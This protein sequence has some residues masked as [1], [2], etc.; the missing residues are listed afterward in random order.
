MR[1][2]LIL[3]LFLLFAMPTLFAQIKI[4]DNPQAIAP[5]SVLELESN[6][7]VFVITRITTQ[8]MNA[9]VPSHGAMIYNTDTQCVHYYNGTLWIN[10]CDS[11]GLTLSDDPVVNLFSTI[12]ITDVAGIKHIEVAPN[13]IGGV[14]IIEDGINGEFH[15]ADHSINENQLAPESVTQ[16]KL[17]ENSVGALQLDNAN[18]GLTAFTNDAG[19]ITGT[20]IVSGDTGNNISIGGDNGAFYDN[21]PVLDAIG[22]NTTFINAHIAADL[23]LLPTNELQNLSYNAGSM[24]LTLSDPVNGNDVIDLSALG[25]TGSDNQNLESAILNASNVLQINIENGNSATV[26]LSSL[27]GGGGNPTDELTDIDFNT[28][29]NILTLTNPA[30]V[31]GATVD[32]STLAGGGSQDLGQVLTQGNDA[33]AIQIKNLSNPSLPQDAATKVY[34]DLSDQNLSEVLALDND[35]GASLIKNILDPVDPQDAATRA[36]VLA[37]VASGGSLTDGTILIGGT[38]NV[39]Q[40]LAIGGDATL[41]NTG[42]LTI[43]DDAIDTDKID[44]AAILLEDLNQN[45]AG[46]GQII[47]WNNT[48]GVWEIADDDTGTPTLNDSNIFVGDASNTPVGVTLSGDATINN[49]GAL[50]IANDAITL[51]KIHQNGATTDGQIM[52]WDNTGS[53]WVVGDP[54]SHTGSS[55]SLFFADV[56]GDPAQAFHPGNGNPSLIWDYEARVVTGTAY[57]ALGIGLDGEDINNNVKVHIIDN[58]GGNVSY[59]LEIQNRLESTGSATGILFA[60]DRFNDGKGALVFQRT[61]SYGVGDF[62]FVLNQNSSG[63]E[64]PNLSTDKAFTVKTNGDIRLYRGIDVDGSGTATALGTAGQVLTSTGSGVEWGA[65]GGGT[66]NQNLTSATLAG[67]DLTITIEDGNPTTADLSTLTLDSELAAAITTSETADGDK[68]D[69]NEIQSVTAADGTIVVTP[70]GTNDFTIAV[71]TISGGASGNIATNSITQGDIDTDAIGAGEILSGAVSSD[72]ISDN[73]IANV[74]IATGAA[75]DGSKIVPNFAVQ[76]NAAAGMTTGADIFMNG[77]TVIPDYVFQKYFVGNSTLKESYNFNSLEEIE[78]FVKKYHHLPGIKSAATVK[79]EGK[80]NL[81]VS[82]LQNLEKI[83]ELFLHTIEQGNKIK[84]LQSE[85]KNLTNRLNS[86]QEDLEEIKALL[87]K[88]N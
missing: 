50:T 12:V 82:N 41:A 69:T 11:A 61:G 57:G 47:K 2:P 86:I 4:G 76:I 51:D 56:N 53:E 18:I 36:Y 34:V 30:T 31:L 38:G 15:I 7:R 8:Q 85:N 49:L 83:E 55:K 84:S 52:K 13:S 72:E 44:D 27:A 1:N 48:A 6:D 26:D 39:A 25:G 28:T 73:S 60:N 21:Q 17:S 14:Q 58:V 24:Q 32:L 62:H 70:V 33:G 3:L 74:D 64:A 65:G 40:Q 10:L 67:T 19:F 42:V 63:R 75:I 88:E 43:V 46:D 79:K 9:I 68:D 5:T 20:D 37:T 87:K 16:D 59:P 80:W 29:T 66:D 71:G 23:D 78:V 81:S 54:A 22:A 45:S 35:G 77:N